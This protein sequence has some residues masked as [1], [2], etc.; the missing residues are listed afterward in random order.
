MIVNYNTGQ[1]LSQANN[2]VYRRGVR[3]LKVAL[4]EDSDFIKSL[5]SIFQPSEKVYDSDFFHFFENET[6]VNAL[7][8]CK[9]QSNSSGTDQFAHWNYHQADIKLILLTSDDFLKTVC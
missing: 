6:I 9:A 3:T 2:I 4:I 7:N 8:I 5:S 1:T